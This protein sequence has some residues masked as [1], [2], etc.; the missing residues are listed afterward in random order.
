MFVTFKQFSCYFGQ[1]QNG[2]DMSEIT[3]C[4]YQVNFSRSQID[5][6]AFFFKFLSIALFSSSSHLIRLKGFL[7]ASVYQTII[8]IA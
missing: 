8:V 6:K 4:I 2:I 1:Q 3:F 7:P 5:G